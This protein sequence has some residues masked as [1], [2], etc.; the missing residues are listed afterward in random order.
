MARW[1]RRE[2]SRE[3]PRLEGGGVEEHLGL[4]A[5]LTLP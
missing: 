2:W 5:L 1:E 4:T 3:S